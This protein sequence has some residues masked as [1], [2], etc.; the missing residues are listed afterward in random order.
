MKIKVSKSTV[1][2]LYSELISHLRKLFVN[3]GFKFINFQ[4]KKVLL[5][6]F[7]LESLRSIQ[8]GKLMLTLDKDSLFLRTENIRKFDFNY[9]SYYQSVPIFQLIN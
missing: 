6:L 5:Y 7:Q 8:F 9:L 4:E 3:R 2:R 1:I